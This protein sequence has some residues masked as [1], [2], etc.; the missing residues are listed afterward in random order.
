MARD[1][2][3][4]EFSEFLRLAHSRLI[5]E[6][7]ELRENPAIQGPGVCPARPV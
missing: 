3:L 2:L 4:T 7:P 1:E 6:I 5:E